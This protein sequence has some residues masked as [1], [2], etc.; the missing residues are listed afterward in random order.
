MPWLARPALA[1]IP[2]AFLAG[3]GLARVWLARAPN[4]IA[5]DLAQPLPVVTAWHGYGAVCF[6]ILALAIACATLG[7]GLGLRAM[8]GAQLRAT[9][10]PGLR[11]RPARDASISGIL[12][13]ATLAIV[14]AWTWPFVFSSDTYAYA[15]YGAL[16]LHGL[17]PYSPVPPALHGA[18]VDAARRQWSGAFPPCVYGP[19]FVGLARTI[20]A[21]TA[22]LSPAATLWTF[23]VLAAAAFLAGVPCLWAA[24]ERAGDERRSFAVCAY[25]LNP[26]VLWSVAEGHN[27]AFLM[28]V[29]LGAAALGRAGRTPPAGAAA[30]LLAGLSALVKAPGALL[31]GVAAAGIWRTGGP[32]DRATA[33][34]MLAGLALAAALAVPPLLPALRAIGAHGRYEPQVS[35]QGLAG[36][37]VAAA[38][39][40]GAA[41]AGVRALARRRRAGY[42]WLGIAVVAALPNT[43]PWYALWLAPC[44][45]AGGRGRASVALWSATIFSVVRYLP[46]ATGDMGNVPL[47][48]AAAVATLPLAFA[49]SGHRRPAP[50]REKASLPT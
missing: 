37:W 16:A 31:A 45:I 19:L 20:A 25:A 10:G 30:G 23:R 11:P 28:L 13:L 46:D 48:A 6:A 35:L 14:S 49:L 32:A 17:D 7:L 1:L 21:A 2:A 4:T 38:V 22:G 44:A 9:A 27:D 5:V 12:T 18:L 3:A 39:A 33:R 40:A 29:V 8:L 15:A 26:V 42:P 43:Y 41:V 47:R 50:S 34:W 24:L 36:P